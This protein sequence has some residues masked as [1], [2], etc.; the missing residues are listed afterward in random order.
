MYLFSPFLLCLS[1]YIHAQSWTGIID[2]TR[3]IDWS[4]AGVLGGIP[5]RR[6]ICTTLN[7]GATTSQINT[8][9]QNCPGGQVVNLNAGS[10]SLTSG[11][12]LKSNVT[13]RGAGADQ[14]ILNFTGF[15]TG[16]GG[17][18]AYAIGIEGNYNAAWYGR[19]PAPFGA[20]PSNIKAWIGT[21]GVT[22]AYTKGATVLNL[23]DVPTGSPNLS[24]GD[25]LFLYQ[26]DDNAT[27]STLFVCQ[28]TSAGCSREG[29]RGEGQQ[30]A[31][32]VTNISGTQVTITPGIYMDNWTASK[33]PQVYWW[34][35]DIRGAG[36]EDLSIQAGSNSHYMNIS[37]FEASDCW[38]KGVASTETGARDH[39][40]IFLS[41]NITVKDSYFYGS[42]VG[43]CNGSA[44]G[45]GVE[46]W[47][48]SAALVQNNIL[49]NVQAPFVFSSATNGSVISYN[50]EVGGATGLAA[51][52]EG[53]LMN[54]FEGNNSDRVRFDTYHGTQNISTLF[55]NRLRGA[56]GNAAVDIW[57]YNRYMNAIGNV[58]GTIG[59]TTR[60]QCA[61]PDSASVCNQYVSPN[62]VFRLGY[63]G[64]GVTSPE[65]GVP[66]DANV[67]S[68]MMRWG[69]Y[70]VVN[71]STRFVGTEV[72]STI[73]AY[74]NS[75]P[76]NQV[77]PASF[78][79]STRPSWWPAAKPWPAIGPDVTGGNLAGVGGHAYTIPAQD[80]Y[81]NEMRGPADGTGSALRFNANTCYGLSSLAAPTNLRIVRH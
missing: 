3:A 44:T 22:G 18:G 58:L 2:S 28:N 70:D 76:V 62:S 25:M 19:V 42:C 21:N 69:N 61:T 53:F 11:I 68:T 1:G 17:G 78:Y 27:T 41:R 54:L 77:L 60:Y 55:R 63:A 80:C 45:Y 35:G 14:T 8:A 46:T 56:G 73:G 26:T 52:E 5:D 9:I 50:Y 51:H 23:A 43:G 74:R 65:A 49:H 59:A 4:N 79:L 48:V 20:N 29:S 31:V 6:T 37:I 39:V 13:L 47:A 64:G 15:T 33:N 81:A 67:V 24:V 66:A 12:R 7:P 57:A 10:Y 34:G 38:I 71:G 72:P 75:V 36:V 40:L 16:I 32:L 30:Q